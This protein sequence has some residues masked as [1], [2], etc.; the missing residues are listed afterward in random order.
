MNET[1][2]PAGILTAPL[3]WTVCAPMVIRS[4][5]TETLAEA[6]SALMASLKEI[7]PLPALV[8]LNIVAT[9]DP[10]LDV[11]LFHVRDPA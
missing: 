9:G 10:L 6:T 8:L 4:G 1:I 7:P 2:F 11:L 5:D 3:V